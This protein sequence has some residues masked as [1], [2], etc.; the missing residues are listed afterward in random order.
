MQGCKGDASHLPGSNQTAVVHATLS[1]YHP[2]IDGFLL[3]GSLLQKSSDRWTVLQRFLFA[4][5]K[6]VN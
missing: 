5:F 1:L 4:E 3:H 6:A 2:I